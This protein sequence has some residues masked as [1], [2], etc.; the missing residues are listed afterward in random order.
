M[1]NNYNIAKINSNLIEGLRSISNKIDGYPTI[2]FYNQG[3]EI[4]E[5]TK[6]REV[7]DFLEY[8]WN[9]YVNQVQFKNNENSQQQME[10]QQR[11]HQQREQQK[12]EQQMEQQQ[13]EEQQREHQ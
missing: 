3:Q 12:R 11:E 13:R 7:N 2:K 8:L 9:D 5:F 10:Q 4:E 6:G 1:N